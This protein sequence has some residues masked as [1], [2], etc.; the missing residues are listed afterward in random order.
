[1]K[2]TVRFL[3][4]SFLFL[5]YSLAIGLASFADSGSAFSN[6]ATAEKEGYFTAISGNLLSPTSQTKT[7]A[8]HLGDSSASAFEGPL[9]A[10][11]AANRAAERLIES[12][13]SH[14]MA[15]MRGLLIRYRKSD[16]IFPFHYFW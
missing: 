11:W 16:L 13:F 10:H 9:S 15:S 3:A 14:Y 8:N 6:N 7:A 1:M 2:N 5:S 4:A 12:E